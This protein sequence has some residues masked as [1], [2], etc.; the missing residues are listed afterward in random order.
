[1]KRF[2]EKVD[3]LQSERCYQINLDNSPL[4][5]PLKS[6]LQLPTRKLAEKI[7]KEWSDVET[8][9]IPKR[10]PIFSLA[11]TAIDRVATQRNELSEEM[12]QYIM[13]D[14]LC[15]RESEDTKLQEHQNKFWDPWLSWANTEFEF[16]LKL[17]KGVM[18]INQDQSNANRLMQVIS[19]MNIW[20][21]MCFARTTTLTGSVILA[22]A[23]IRKQVTPDTLFTVASLDELYQI[24][25]WGEDDESKARHVAVKNELHD[26]SDFYRLAE[27]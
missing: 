22:L 16:D 23:F 9:I 3:I 4:K 21:F 13:N 7:A 1:M 8:D 14:L 6:I 10:M 11:V 20:T 15:Y 25:R 24:A 18:P 26:L 19:R 2:Y 5:T 17:A 12:Q 27:Q